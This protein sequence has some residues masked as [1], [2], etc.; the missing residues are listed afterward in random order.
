VATRN[1]WGAIRKLPSK[2]FQA[3]YIAPDGSRRTA[4]D[5]FK[6][7]TEASV[8]LAEVRT[9]ITHGKWQ[10]LVDKGSRSRPEAAKTNF[11]DYA[12]RHIALQT[13]RSGELLRASTQELYRRLLS[14]NLKSFLDMDVESITRNEVQQW[15]ADTIVKGKKTTVSKAY[16]LLSAILRRAEAEGLVLSNPCQIKGAHSAI[17]GKVVEAPTADE[18][19]KLV[20]FI[21]PTYRTLTALAAYGGFRYG[22]ITELR[23]KDVRAVDVGGTVYYTFKVSRAVTRVGGR[24]V[25][26]KPKS[27]K[28]LRDV[29]VTSALTQLISEHLLYEVG[30]GDESLLFPNKDNEHLPHYVYIKAFNRA[31][32]RAGITRNGIT[33]HSLRHFGGTYLHLAGATLPELMTWLGDSSIAAVQRYLH[34]TSRTPEI[35]SRMEVSPN[36]Q[37]QKPETFYQSS[38]VETNI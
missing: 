31:K 35:V 29:P 23:R 7:R 6:T 38:K 21:D 17:S 9:E 2:R 3:S 16:K 14:N 12:L 34:V 27:A 22:E 26:G 19:R 33:P 13:N 18:V 5:T 4:P 24:I 32:V 36:F 30:E 20:E 15:Y 37:L 28:S 10:S 1:T 8:Y 11:K 25:I